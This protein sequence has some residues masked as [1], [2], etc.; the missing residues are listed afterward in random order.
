MLATILNAQGDVEL[1]LTPMLIKAIMTRIESENMIEFSGIGVPI[2]VTCNKVN[3]MGTI[4]CQEV[5]PTLRNH[6]EK[7]K[8]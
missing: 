4:C 2:V 3:I 7:G 5:R 6:E 8:A 1:G